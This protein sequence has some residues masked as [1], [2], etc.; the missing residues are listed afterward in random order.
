M[1]RHKGRGEERGVSVVL[2]A[3]LVMGIIIAFFSAF[4]SAWIP[5]EVS[6]R[7][8]RQMRGVEESFRELR[9]VIE[10]LQA[11]E[12]RSVDVNMGADYSIPLVPN[13]RGVGT[14]SVSP[15]PIHEIMIPPS[16]D[17]FV[18]ENRPNNNFGSENWLRV[19]SQLDNNKR[20]YLKF[21]LENI[22]MGVMILEADLWL[23]C[24]ES[25]LE[26]A[27][28][29]RCRLVENDN[30]S[31]LTITWK[32]AIENY[33]FGAV[34]DNILVDGTG[35][36][37]WSAKDFVAREVTGDRSLSLGLR[38]GNENQ[39]N[40][41]RYASFF[42]KEAGVRTPYLHVTYTT[43][44]P[45]WI[46]TDWVGGR[47]YPTL[48]SEKWY[49]DYNKY[50]TGENE[51]SKKQGE[52]R[53]ENSIP[54]ETSW[55]Q[56]TKVDFENGTSRENLDTSTFPGS[57]ILAGDNIVF[58]NTTNT[59]EY[60]PYTNYT[61]IQR[62]DPGGQYAAPYNGVII[63]WRWYPR[64]TAQG[65]KFKV[66]RHVTG[67]VWTMVGESGPKNL[68]SGM[69][70][71]SDIYLPV[72]AGDRIGGY[73][74]SSGR[75][76]W[77]TTP[78]Y[79]ACRTEGDIRGTSSFT[80]HLDPR[81][82]PIDATLKIYRYSGTLISRVHD[83][84]G[85]ET[86]WRKIS[87]G[88]NLPP[89]TDI[90]LQTRTGDSPT[91][92]ENWSGWSPP[93]KNP[94]GELITSPRARYIQYKVNFST[95]DT[96][97]TPVLEW[98]KIEY[99]TSA[100]YKPSGQLE[101]SV[102]DAGS[103]TDWRT[104][105]WEAETPSIVGEN[106]PVENEPDPLIDWSPLI[107]ENMSPLEHAQAQDNIYETIAEELRSP[108][109]DR[110]WACR[111]PVTINN[112]NNPG[113]LENYQVK[114]RVAYDENMLLN[115]DD[116]RFVEN[117]DLTELSYWIENYKL[118]EN[119]IVWVRVPNIPA[120][121]NK[122]IYMYYG[123]PG[124]PPGSDF[125]ATF[126]NALI[127]D[128]TSRTLGGV[129]RYDWVEV[130]NG[131]TL[132]VQS[133]NILQLFARKIIVD[134]TSRIYATGSGYPGGPTNRLR[135]RQENGYS[136]DG[137]PGTGGG[138]GGYALGTSDGPGGGGGGYAGSGGNG[139]GARGSGDYPGVGGS[140]FG[141][142]SD[143]SIYM[144]SG[145]GSGGLSRN[146]PENDPWN[147][148]GAGGAGGG[149]I[150]LNAGVIEIFGLVTADGGDGA[151]G[152]SNVSS[153]G[154]GGGGGGS[155]G[156]I[157]IEG[158]EVIITGT[159]TAN[160]GKGGARSPTSTGGGPYGGAGGG[161]GGGRIKVFY[162]NRLDNAGATYSVKGG[163]N[164]G[165]SYEAPVAQSGTSGTTYTGVISYP[166]PA[167]S[168][169]SEELESEDRGQRG[170]CLN[171][172]H[173]I[174]G[175]K[176]GYENY[177]FYIRGYSDDENIGVYIWMSKTNSWYFIDNLPRAPGDPI[178]FSIKSKDLNDYIVGGVLSIG[179]F[180]SALDNMQTAIH[181]DY[182]ILELTGHF[183]TEVKVYTRTGNTEN[184]YDGSWNEW[185][186]ATNGGEVP[187]PGARYIQY[188]VD[189]S[190]QR[191]QITPVFK[192]ITI[193][194]RKD[195]EYGTVGFSSGHV[196]Y[197]DQA[198]VYEGGSVILTQG[199]VNVTVLDPVMIRWENDHENENR[200]RVYVNLWIIENERATL[201]ST[202]TR[203]IRVF[204]VDNRA[205][206]IP[207]EGP[208]R[209]S[210]ILRVF[211][212]YRD[213]WSR[214]LRNKLDELE[215]MGVAASLD[216]DTLTLTILGKVESAGV[217]DI[218]YYEYLK[219]LVVE[220]V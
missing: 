89:D 194:H 54:L 10:G 83:T 18:V 205:T 152:M 8:H 23:Y 99:I 211:S 204:C 185:R 121:G 3:A 174:T 184:A 214:Y 153:A 79:Y 12:F 158:N 66:F 50:Y 130:K 169:G 190:T 33:P 160:G 172:E 39:D 43:G 161:G 136:Y 127:I 123:N 88:E 1:L 131:G 38:V 78:G 208:N 203:T 59:A 187:S 21:S 19:A 29:V 34:L 47:T 56:T 20:S 175:V 104:I 210:I 45:I 110:S 195:T 32:K 65:A 28:D 146:A 122:T 44:P 179:Y 16:D 15:A 216:E 155:G 77:S 98:V 74:G 192:E 27:T 35:W 63:Q 117:D 61:Y 149:G 199:E 212:P 218:Y 215:A 181:I 64:A 151:G 106:K 167:A 41:E 72:K 67:T 157:L 134:P 182:C 164:G 124:A 82:L 143:N 96:A 116:L 145:G 133:E 140:T 156:T 62:S 22:P 177:T 142:A 111:R 162:G 132:A 137:R 165:A 53:L 97:H 40:I 81:R 80:D 129:Q 186:E 31:E 219:K 139:G 141:N 71:F 173:R 178:T 37:H 9:A 115:F 128:G 42:S 73:T 144:G 17:A 14:L 126:P 103:H 102:Y 113:A 114:I 202:G 52:V 86:N 196:Y 193:T 49:E 197:P 188:R 135:G 87:W 107:G 55:F 7:E 191:G 4:L 24:Y 70:T 76:Y 58:G 94:A 109:W 118:G 166:E 90:T 36:F 108:W 147:A 120:N 180:D 125:S 100:L 51:N 13:P 6:R 217:K 92:D 57:V 163:D 170:Y 119:A 220:L 189:L 101:S 68:S 84:I 25:T 183:T 69:N 150:R 209:E 112:E 176:L 159:L 201:T 198:Y 85:F 11:G 207:V 148:G 95:K 200:I 46:Q 60:Q 93:Y 213:V 5:R 168:V 2:G 26:N 105:T 30:W 154:S 206:V 171:W 138:T 91:P 75:T 48:E